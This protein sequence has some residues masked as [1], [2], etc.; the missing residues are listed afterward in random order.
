M[1]VLLQMIQNS[2]IMNFVYENVIKNISNKAVELEL[3]K[4]KNNIKYVTI[5]IC[6]FFATMLISMLSY[7]LFYIMFFIS[8]LKCILW[9]F[10]VYNP[11]MNN[12]S[13]DSDSF[14][15]QE[16]THYVS[17]VTQQNVLEYYVVPIFIVLI[18]YPLT[19]I[20]ISGL[21]FIINGLSVATCVACLT[22]Q[23]YRQN[24]CL[25]I[26]DTF[27]NKENRDEDGN[28][29]PGHEGEFHKLLQTIS[30]S[31][32]C[33]IMSTYNLTHN[34]RLMLNQISTTDN[35]TQALSVITSGLSNLTH[36]VEDKLHKY[37]SNRSNQSHKTK[38]NKRK[39]THKSNNTTDHKRKA[40]SADDIE[41]DQEIEIENTEDVNLD[42]F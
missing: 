27:T 20:P 21:S 38:R 30:Y 23:S 10:E 13:F 22:K 2:T 12:T 31:I 4:N 33:T 40:A 39:N 19:Y 42:F 37:Q 15:E 18:M 9:L 29:V 6:L 14:N 35:I 24:C 25:Y 17:N 11:D 8:S 5:G 16:L 26:R 32:D 7:F 41:H 28:Y 3:L 1:P 34:P 36:D